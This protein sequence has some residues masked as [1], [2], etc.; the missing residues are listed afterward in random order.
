MTKPAT[1]EQIAG[2]LRSI[3]GVLEQ[4]R[5]PRRS[6]PWLEQADDESPAEQPC[7]A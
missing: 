5:K 2:V 6:Q 7:A 4:R 1:R 3:D